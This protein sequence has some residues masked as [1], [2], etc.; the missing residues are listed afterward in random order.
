MV[1]KL[2][3]IIQTLGGL[4]LFL[5]GMVV[6]T[7]GLRT[8]AGAAIRRSL[9]RFT[10]T[11]LSG[12]MTGAV[13]TAILQSSS[14]TTVAAVGFVGASLMAFPEALGIVFGANIG[15]TI[16]GWLVA[17]LGLK[18]SLGTIIL[19]VIFIGMVLRLFA[20]GRT[21]TSGIAI[22][23][24]GVIF[25]GISV[26]QQGMAGLEGVITPELLPEDSWSGRL[27]LVAFGILMTIITQSSSAGVAFAL[28]AVFAGT[29]NFHQ[30]AAL[31]I[32]MDVGTTVTALMATIGGSVGAKR[33]GFSHV[34]YNLF[35]GSV[36]L[37]LISPFVWIWQQTI[38][39][40]ITQHAEIA[41]VAFHSFFNLLGVI[42]VLPFARQFAQF[43][44]KI[45]PE[46]IPLHLKK[47]DQVL[48]QQPGLALNEV[49]QVLSYQFKV[50][51]EHI[52]S[53][54]SDQSEQRVDLRELQATLDMVHA[55]LDKIHLQDEKSMDWQRLIELIHT[56]DH[57]QRLHERCEEDEYRA[58]VARDEPI[59][60]DPSE[61]LLAGVTQISQILDDKGW[62]KL[63]HTAQ[64]LHDKIEQDYGPYRV[65]I[66]EQVGRGQID[67][68]QATRLLEAMRWMRRV[69]RHILQINK[70]YVAAILACAT[71]S[72]SKVN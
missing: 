70:H 35:T 67:V 31:V 18:L 38:S 26:M 21:A 16:T 57:M 72:S 71:E 34:I 28:T 30:A 39:E 54:L 58:I 41:L 15:T 22:A 5:L 45:L 59:L 1:E 14:A 10:R 56:M 44:E 4:G 60:D 11:P 53:V 23:G 43:I 50:L 51:L 2:Q 37:F 52:K 36:A 9:L 47:L 40:D 24:F 65:M 48:L 49:Q 64:Q 55:Y 19:P 66:V 46:K 29:I 25:V 42:V 6:M 69:T 20:K 63:V 27:Q 8:L 7:D 32:G 12:A 68:D 33:T 13:S 3:I 62:D 17:T 61:D